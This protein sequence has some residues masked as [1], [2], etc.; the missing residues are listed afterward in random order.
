MLMRNLIATYRYCCK[1]GTLCMSAVGVNKYILECN[2]LNCSEKNIFFFRR[3]SK[4][5]TQDILIDPC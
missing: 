4:H 3:N 5:Y 2:V 1:L